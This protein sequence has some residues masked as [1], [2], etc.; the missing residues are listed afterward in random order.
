MRELYVSKEGKL[1]ASGS[2]SDP[3]HSPQLIN[4]WQAHNPNTPFNLIL[5]DDSYIRDGVLIVNEGSKITGNGKQIS[6]T[7]QLTPKA[8]GVY[9]IPHWVNIGGIRSHGAYT[10]GDDTRQHCHDREWRSNRIV[11]IINGKL[12]RLA[13][14]RPEGRTHPLL[15]AVEIGTTVKEKNSSD[16][17]PAC[18]YMDMTGMPQIKGDMYVS[19]VP[20]ASIG[21]AWYEHIPV[22]NLNQDTGYFEL[23]NRDYRAWN[24]HLQFLPPDHKGHPNAYMRFHAFEFLTL[25]AGTGEHW[26]DYEKRLVYV[27][28]P[29][30][31][32]V[33]FAIVPEEIVAI[34]ADNVTLEG[35]SIYGSQKTGV[36][37]HANGTSLIGCN[38]NANVYAG[39]ESP[40]SEG[41][42]VKGGNYNGNGRFGLR[43][44]SI[45]Q[46]IDGIE[47]TGGVLFDRL[48]APIWCRGKGTTIKNCYLHDGGSSL[49]DFNSDYVSILDNKLYDGCKVSG[50]YGILYTFTSSAHDKH[51]VIRGNHIRGCYQN[52]RSYISVQMIYLDNRSNGFDITENHFED[53]LAAIRT[54]AGRLNFSNNK[55][56]NILRAGYLGPK[57][58]LES[59]TVDGNEWNGTTKPENIHEIYGARGNHQL[60]GWGD[61]HPELKTLGLHTT[62]VDYFHTKANQG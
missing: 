10:V 61:W 59:L 33:E 56:T 2:K 24:T 37:V 36:G 60:F 26:V 53:G 29:E 9:E 11:P 23:D 4:D 14:W 49:I 57:C 45:G 42:T 40:D 22:I 35:V 48:N 6:G 19:G 15:D 51:N 54:Y 32:V 17:S 38:A 3:F 43:S 5:L 30:G 25:G 47:G 12:S 13:T 16:Y 21:Y 18:P 7:I 34:Q 46:V 50:D 1:G 28:A 44:R 55:F 58:P 20:D 52:H 31:A 27:D 62:A 8:P 41:L 39:V